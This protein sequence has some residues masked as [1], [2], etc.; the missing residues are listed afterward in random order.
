M[1]N[2]PNATSDHNTNNRRY[3]PLKPRNVIVESKDLFTF[4]I[5]MEQNFLSGKGLQLQLENLIR[6]E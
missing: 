3:I 6:T 1:I 5:A 2:I 4:I